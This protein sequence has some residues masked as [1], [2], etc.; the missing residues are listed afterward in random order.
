MSLG[1]SANIVV[2][3][4]GFC[5]SGS[6]I[7]RMYAA[8]LVYGSSKVHMIGS[9]VRSADIIAHFTALFACSLGG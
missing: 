6:R 5:V 3:G 9:L 7:R 4:L 1:S 8:P 2:P